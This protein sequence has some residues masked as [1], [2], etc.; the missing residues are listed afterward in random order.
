MLD[1][2]WSLDQE[3]DM[4]S[5]D[6]N[7]MAVSGAA[8]D[9][10]AFPQFAAAHARHR[11]SEAGPER[12]PLELMQVD[13]IEDVI[14]AARRGEPI[15][16]V[17]SEDRENEGDVVIVAEFAT[18]DVI[19]FMARRASGLICVALTEM[20]A[21]ELGLSR[22]SGS[23]H[24]LRQTAFTQSIE[25][26]DGITTGIS[27]ADRAQTIATAIDPDRGPEAI[28]SPGHMFPLIA[29]RGGVLERPG[30]TEA[31]VDIA[32][33]AGLNPAGVI[34]E[35]M[36]DDGRMARLPDLV[37]F[38]AEHDLRLG[39]IADLIKWR[40]HHDRLV[41]RRRQEGHLL[42][43]D[44]LICAGRHV[45]AT[46]LA[47]GPM[48]LLLGG[49]PSMSNV[50]DTSPGAAFLQ[51]SETFAPQPGQVPSDVAIAITAQILKDAGIDWV[52][53]ADPM[54]RLDRLQLHGICT[55]SAESHVSCSASSMENVAT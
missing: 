19:A 28:S 51:L 34:C 25:A 5:S 48:P 11:W 49:V 13:P 2:I 26:K 10:H 44:D 40:L 30:H 8:H 20:R 38:S 45:L 53:G 1:G 55:V 37:R 43:Y 54:Q 36:L 12:T 52:V 50:R 16:L 39:T 23:G 14:D 31:A 3:C 42:H 21:S 24:C 33:L 32:R 6:A 7:R 41:R 35:I 18:P 15:V 47:D 9:R 27:A 4:R 17:D 46:A 22:S 29:R